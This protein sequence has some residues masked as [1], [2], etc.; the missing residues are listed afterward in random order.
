MSISDSPEDI[1]AIL[2]R[3]TKSDIQFT[4][5]ENL[6]VLKNRYKD[7]QIDGLTMAPDDEK[8]AREEAYQFIVDN[9][10]K[11]DPAKF[12]VRKFREIMVE[13]QSDAIGDRASQNNAQIRTLIGD[14]SGKT[15]KRKALSIL[16]KA[17][18]DIF[19]KASSAPTKEVKDKLAEIRKKNPDLYKKLFG[20]I[21]PDQ[22]SKRAVK[23]VKENSGEEVIEKKEET[24]TDAQVTKA[25]EAQLGDMSVQEAENILLG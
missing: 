24:E 11:L 18:E 25:F 10:D 15:W 22:G 20:D 6:E 19:E 23:E 4:V 17:E 8:Q 14:R 13:I 3:A 21:T 1:K 12:S 9:K 7:M 16:N 5:E 2:S